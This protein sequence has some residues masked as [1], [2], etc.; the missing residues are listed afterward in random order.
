M[1]MDPVACALAKQSTE[2]VESYVSTLGYQLPPGG[3]GTATSLRSTLWERP[4][5]SLVWVCKVSSALTLCLPC[6]PH[7]F[8]I[9]RDRPS[10]LGL[11]PQLDKIQKS[12]PVLPIRQPFQTI[13]AGAASHPC[14]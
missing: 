2:E 14:C 10:L 8:L 1:N 5:L 3:S 4:R 13:P 6:L 12:L 7:V 9:P 11:R